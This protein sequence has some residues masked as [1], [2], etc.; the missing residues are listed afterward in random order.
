MHPW[1]EIDEHLAGMMLDKKLK[2]VVFFVIAPYLDAYNRAVPLVKSR[3]PILTR[4]GKMQ[5]VWSE[6]V[7]LVTL[8]KPAILL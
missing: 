8:S 4:S 6:M 7:D 5:T 2:K 3:F 1:S